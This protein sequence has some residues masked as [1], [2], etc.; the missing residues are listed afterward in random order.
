MDDTKKAYKQ[1][2][3]V[4]IEEQKRIWDERGKGYYGEFLVFNH[5]YGEIPGMCKI[6]M[7]C[8]IPVEG[9]KSTEVDL[10]LIHETGIY[11]FEM[12]HYKGDIYVNP[13]GNTWTQYFRT[14]S[15]EVFHNPIQQNEYHISAIKKLFPD[16]QILTLTLMSTRKRLSFR[17]DTETTSLCWSAHTA[18]TL[19]D[20][21]Q[22]GKRHPLPA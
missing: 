6:L 11:S 20:S 1:V 2:S 14:Q 13:D 22:S 21:S 4:D 9:N 19:W 16:I 12:K 10:I 18:V 15:N 5:L 7:N 17:T 3:G 8:E